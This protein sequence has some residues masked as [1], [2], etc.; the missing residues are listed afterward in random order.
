MRRPRARLLR[1]MAHRPS[2]QPP[3]RQV[4]GGTMCRGRV[5]LPAPGSNRRTTAAADR[6]ATSTFRVGAFPRMRLLPQLHPTGRASQRPTSPL[7][8]QRRFAFSW[9][10]PTG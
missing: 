3:A 7:R 1:R 10:G 8:N 5:V 2:E 4:R 9:G 6:C